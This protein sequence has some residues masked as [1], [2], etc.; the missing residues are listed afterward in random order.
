MVT[1]TGPILDSSGQPA[2]GRLTVRAS[3]PFDIG[4][5]HYTRALGAATVRAGVPYRAGNEPWT[6]PAT[7]EGVWLEVTQD[8]DGDRLFRFDTVVPDTTTLTYSQ[9]LFNRGRGAGG[10]APFF[11]DLSGGADFPPEAVI[12]DWGIDLTADPIEIYE[13]G[14]D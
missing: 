10:P 2:S 3:A 13:K 8:L 5:A 7:P 1:I 6:L 4:D 9:L 14:A 11:W 12:G